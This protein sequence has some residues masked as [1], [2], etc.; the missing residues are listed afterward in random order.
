MDLEEEV[1]EELLDEAGGVWA[2]KRLVRSCWAR[3]V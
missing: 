2:S 3:M 1:Q